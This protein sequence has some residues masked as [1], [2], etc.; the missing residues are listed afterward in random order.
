MELVAYQQF[1]DLE[2]S[3]WWFLGRRSIFLR[4]L[5]ER[6]GYR[7]TPCRSAVTREATYRTRGMVYP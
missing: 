5:E 2:E 4:L 1:R 6:P 7:F 3:H